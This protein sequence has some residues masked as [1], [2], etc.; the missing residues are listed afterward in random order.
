MTP[1][2]DHLEKL[3][4]YAVVAQLGSFRKAAAR[5]RISQPALSQ[6]VQILES[7]LGKRLLVRTSRGVIPTDE[8][9]ALRTF[10]EKLVADLEVLD[11]RLTGSGDK[12][13]GLVRFGAF[14]SMTIALF[15]GFVAQLYEQFPKL[16]VSI[17]SGTDVTLPGMLVD[18]EIHIAI[19]TPMRQSR[20][21]LA[22]ELFVD[23]Y[24]FYVSP[25]RTGDRKAA[26]LVLVATAGDD[27][28]HTILEYLEESTS[29]RRGTIAL[30]TFEAVKAFTRSG[31]GIGILPSLVA[32]PDVASGLLRETEIAG[33]PS[34]G[35][36]E[37][38]IVAH[39]HTRSAEDGRV[40]RVVE[41]LKRYAAG[42]LAGVA[43]RLGQK[44][45]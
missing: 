34:S 1:L 20:H 44:G 45:A 24:R 22:E 42:L 36:G 11:R 2:G 33:A 13:S 35:F 40:V 43:G 28:G 25:A 31:V 6:S 41:E 5:L 30:T 17:V 4:A 37:H 12:M 26:P 8:G 7:V 3:R 29:R 21:I 14:E 27:A 38:R 32:Q 16:A 15:P 19:S 39:M 18:R 23:S 9:A 10:A